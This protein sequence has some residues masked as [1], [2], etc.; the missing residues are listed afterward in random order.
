MFEVESF[1]FGWFVKFFILWIPF[2]FIILIF[3]PGLKWKLLFPICGAIGI[4]FALL[5]KSMKGPIS[6]RGY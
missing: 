1:S 4:L 2:T 5:G 3:A 6:R